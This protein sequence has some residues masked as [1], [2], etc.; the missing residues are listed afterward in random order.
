[1][2]EQDERVWSGAGEAGSHALLLSP[3]GVPVGHESQVEYLAAPDPLRGQ[4]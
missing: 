1:M 3:Q 2:L 4:E